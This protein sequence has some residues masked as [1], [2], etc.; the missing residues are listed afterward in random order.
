MVFGQGVYVNTG[1]R[2]ILFEGSNSG[3]VG[4]NRDDRDGGVSYPIHVGTSTTNGN[5]AY[6]SATGVW[7]NGSSREFK[8][9]FQSL[10]G[11]CLLKN[12]SGLSLKSWC[13][14]GTDERHI[15]PVA[16]D[17]ASAF[18]VGTEKT[19][20]TIDNK[21]LAASDVAGVALAGVQELMKVIEKQNEKIKDLENQI[22]ELKNR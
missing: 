20:G 13:Y 15:G 4:I 16:E 10:D 19:D 14:K 17:F 21:Y 1:N 3:R 6:L 9:R 12:I 22:N 7:N 8:D 11:N 18:N 2:V 5:G